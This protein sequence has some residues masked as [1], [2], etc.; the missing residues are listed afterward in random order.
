MNM[1]SGGGGVLAAYRASYSNFYLLY[2][3]GP[4]VRQSP[5]RIVVGHR[6]RL[7]LQNS[8]HYS[9]LPPI[10]EETVRS[11]AAGACDGENLV[12]PGN[13]WSSWKDSVL[14]R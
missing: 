13:L 10:S 2:I 9:S 1:Q 4:V 6:Y 12:N 7:G 8:P 3:L 14:A 5:L 11:A